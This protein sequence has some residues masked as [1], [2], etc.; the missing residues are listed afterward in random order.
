MAEAGLL[1]NR[2]LDDSKIH[3]DKLGKPLVLGQL[4]FT[5]WASASN[6]TAEVLDGS[7]VSSLSE[8]GCTNSTTNG[9]ITV[10]R[11][12]LYRLVLNLGKV[13]SASASGVMD[14]TI[15]KNSA[16]LSPTS[17]TL[18]LL[19]PAV[20]NNS[21]SAR[22]EQVIALVKGDV[23]RAVVTGT[24]GGI[25]TIAAGTLSV[26]MLGDDLDNVTQV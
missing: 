25:I 3:P 21:M 20:V 12:G 23:I 19:Q 15:Q 1:L 18:G 11:D 10:P 16:A 9:T 7:G 14:F 17:C 26:E 13:S 24:V 6:P 8:L 2:A 22:C 5:A 4:A